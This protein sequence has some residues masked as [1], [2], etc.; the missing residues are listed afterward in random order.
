MHFSKNWHL[1]FDC[2]AYLSSFI[3]FRYSSSLPQ[4]NTFTLIRDDEKYWLHLSIGAILGAYVFGSLN[5]SMNGLFRLGHSVAGALFGAVLFVEFY[6]RKNKIIGST[7]TV[8]V[9]PVV[10]GIIIGRLGCF[11]S[12]LD[13]ET[14]GIETKSFLG[15]DFG[16][17]I[18]RHPVQL[19][20]SF[21]MIIFLVIVWRLKKQFYSIYQSAVFYLFIFYYSFQ[22]FIWEFFKPYPML[23][24][25]LNIFHFVCLSLNV[26]SIYMI[27]HMFRRN[28]Q[29]EN[30]YKV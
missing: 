29:N 8:F 10:I 2:I 27:L 1:F 22:R 28:H 11:F 14:F 26:Y 19:Y 6:K 12:G 16:D 7:G 25:K 30:V 9:L 17:K 18:F 24:Y 20:E 13:D 4:N 3:A 15:V 5:L 23:F 21:S